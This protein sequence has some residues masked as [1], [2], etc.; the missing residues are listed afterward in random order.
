ML[1]SNSATRIGLLPAYL[2]IYNGR[3]HHRVQGVG[4]TPP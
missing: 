3:K 2:R 4:L 1:Y